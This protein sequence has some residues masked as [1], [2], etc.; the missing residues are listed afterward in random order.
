MR[1]ITDRM[2]LNWMA[3]EIRVG[4]EPV[5]F[6]SLDELMG[7]RNRWMKENEPSYSSFREAIDFG[8][9]RSKAVEG[10]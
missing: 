6:K 2:R 4:G 1:K 7:W 8:M 3:G 5:F 9:H 10:K